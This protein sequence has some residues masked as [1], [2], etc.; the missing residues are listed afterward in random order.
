M[1]R[2]FQ[3]FCANAEGG[4]QFIR[5]LTSPV[6]EHWREPLSAPRPMIF[7]WHSDPDRDAGSWPGPDALYSDVV[8]FGI[9]SNGG[10]IPLLRSQSRNARPVPLGQALHSCNGTWRKSSSSSLS[11]IVPLART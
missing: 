10:S 8:F 7:P 2:C 11:V 5:A 4:K 6:Y 3:T 9:S 1:F